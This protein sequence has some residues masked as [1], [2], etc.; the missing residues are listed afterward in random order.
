MAEKKG[1]LGR[2][3]GALIPEVSNTQDRMERPADGNPI[4]VFF[5]GTY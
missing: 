2:G 5:G 3:I 4:S 1:G